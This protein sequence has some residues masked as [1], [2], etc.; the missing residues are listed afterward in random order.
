MPVSYPVVFG[1]PEIAIFVLAN[2]VIL[3]IVGPK[4]LKEFGG[5]GKQRGR[6][7]KA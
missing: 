4:L 3:L 7:P 5:A 1:P 2:V 6:A